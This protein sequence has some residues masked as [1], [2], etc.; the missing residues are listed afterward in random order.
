M[1]VAAS[2]NRLL[3]ADD[4]AEILSEY[5]RMFADALGPSRA[6][7]LE[8]ELFGD[9]RAGDA[10]HFELETVT[11]GDRAVAAVRAALAAGRPFPVVFL[12]VRMPP[13]PNGIETARA[14]RAIDP[15]VHIVI[16]TGFADM[17]PAE[18][19]AQVQPPDRLFYFEK[20]FRAVELRQLV[21]ALTA[22]WQA[23]REVAAAHADLEA[24][25]ARRTA[26]LVGTKEAAER[27]SASKTRFLANMSHELRTPLNAVIGFS[28]FMLG[29]PL[30]RL[31]HEKYREYL[32]DIRD[33]GAHLLSLIN[34]IL[35]VA[36]AD[37]GNLVLHEEIFPLSE[38]VQG[39]LR[40]VMPQAQVG[41]L[42]LVQA[43]ETPT[44]QILGDK[45]KLVQV[46]T[47]LLSNAVKFTPAGGRVTLAARR[48]ATGA[49][50][51]TVAD[52]GIGMRKADIPRA[53]ELFAQVDDQR[54]RQYGGTGLGLPL[55]LALVELHGGT[56]DI[57][58]E[59]GLGTTVTVILPAIRLGEA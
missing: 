17:S 6:Q 52:T 11:Q 10:V 26:E 13:G 44:C 36:K 16:I 56:L 27:A 42:A 38:V 33:S 18:I 25:V 35:E 37:S 5:V 53:L 54:N 14:I 7:R 51:I 31:G 59:L 2:T 19:A 4:E 45:T 21:T 55:A 46:L 57:D 12:D 24:Q 22:K 30:G 3:V 41:D 15:D 23:E 1:N 58:S 39:A 29:E 28:E 48:A 40:H 8:S 32:G 43:V 50:V 49:L 20:P 34:S 47:N 9:S